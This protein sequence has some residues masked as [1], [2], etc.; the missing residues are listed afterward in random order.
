MASVG[1][2]DVTPK[3]IDEVW[4]ATISMF[5]SCI[6]FAFSINAIWEVINQSKESKTKFQYLCPY[7]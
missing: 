3:N 6:V 4:V 7:T 1:Y 5:I 2:G